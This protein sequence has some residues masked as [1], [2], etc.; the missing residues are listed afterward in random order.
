MTH[1]SKAIDQV[2]AKEAKELKAHGQEPVLTGSRWWLLKR[3]E[4]LSETQ[5]VKLKELLKLNLKTVR[6]YLLKEDLGR[7]WN[8]KAPGWAARFLDEWC[9]RT[10]RSR[11][12]PMKK[13]ARML[14][15]HRGLLLNWFRA[16][17]QIALGAVEGLNNKA[18]VTSRKAYGYRSF[19]VLKISLYHTLG[20][21]PE[22]EVTHKF[23]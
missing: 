20:D 19:D 5:T 21:L 18:K 22:P 8:Y 12:T 4:N 7:F 10:M 17:G 23:C 6:A 9:R 14:R 15:S 16:K 11:L 1:V 2:R 3:P 13:V